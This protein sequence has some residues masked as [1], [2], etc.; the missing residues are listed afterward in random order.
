[1]ILRCRRRVKER[2]GGCARPG[3]DFVQLIIDNPAKRIILKAVK[4]YRDTADK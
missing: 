3:R 1:M 4:N 2:L